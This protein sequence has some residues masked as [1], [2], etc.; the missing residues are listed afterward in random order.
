MSLP[1]FPVQ[2]SFFFLFLVSCFYSLRPLQIV[3]VK[4]SCG[5]GR[6]VI[7]RFRGGRVW[8]I[9][10]CFPSCLS[11]HTKFKEAHNCTTYAKRGVGSLKA[12]SCGVF[13]SRPVHTPSQGVILLLSGEPGWR[14]SSCFIYL[15]YYTCY[16]PV[17]YVM[18]TLRSTLPNCEAWSRYERSSS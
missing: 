9:A 3:L 16:S 15:L 1:I 11:L 13:H 17:G 4:W 18:T 2:F 6:R 8:G 10:P 12:P 14:W 7:R 5:S